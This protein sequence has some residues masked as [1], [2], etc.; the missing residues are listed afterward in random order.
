MQ[1]LIE[2]HH[3]HSHKVRETGTVRSTK[4]HY[5]IVVRPE[6]ISIPDPV[7]NPN[8]PISSFVVELTNYTRL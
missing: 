2:R 6:S 8:L 4:L 3:V 1:E 7:S 5:Q